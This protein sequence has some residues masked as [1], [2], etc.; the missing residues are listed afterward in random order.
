MNNFHVLKNNRS[1]VRYNNKNQISQ[2]SSPRNRPGLFD[3]FV[4]LSPSAIN[5]FLVNPFY[6]YNLNHPNLNQ[7]LVDLVKFVNIIT[8]QPPKPQRTRAKVNEPLINLTPFVC[9]FLTMPPVRNSTSTT[10]TS[11]VIE[12]MDYYRYL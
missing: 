4:V 1:S 12:R 6:V 8:P 7:I 3:Q 10:S 9:L 5:N 2:F 11:N